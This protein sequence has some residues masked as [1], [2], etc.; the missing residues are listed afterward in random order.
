MGALCSICNFSV[1]IKWFQN[2]NVIFLKSPLLIRHC[3]PIF[4]F[5]F[6]QNSPKEL[7]TVTICDSS[8]LILSGFHP[9]L[10]QNCS[11]KVTSGLHVPI[12]WQFLVLTL[13]DTLQGWWP[14]FPVEM[15]P[16]WLWDS[17]LL[18]F[19]LISLVLPSPPP[20]LHS[21]SLPNP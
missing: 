18:A 21:P 20:L 12:Q 14:T 1:N 3:S 6:Y 10:P 16:T 17:A 15:P 11:V 2:K 8:L 19:P 5:L 7:S 13:L 4:C 9:N